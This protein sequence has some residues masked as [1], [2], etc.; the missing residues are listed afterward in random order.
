MATITVN[1]RMLDEERRISAHRLGI[2]AGV[3]LGC[4]H[5]TWSILVSTGWAQPI[6]DFVFWL[7][8]IEPPYRVGPFEWTRAAGLILVTSG[9][10]YALGGFAAAIW[11]RLGAGR[12]PGDR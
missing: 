3:L 1:W 7:H 4:G 12:A 6:I 2:A 9:I 11:N 10:G 8:F 5:L